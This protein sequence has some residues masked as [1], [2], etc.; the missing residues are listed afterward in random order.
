M[1]NITLR[2]LRYFDALA[3]TA[4]FGRAAEA[5]AISQPAL[6]VQIKELEEHLGCTLFE[7]TP[8]QV[9][10][11]TLG[12]AFL[13][14]SRTILRDVDELTDLARSAREHL[15]GELRIGI[16]PTIA[17]YMLPSIV[18][19]IS[20]QFSNVEIHVRETMTKTLIRELNEG[21]IDIAIVALPIDEP[22]LSESPLFD[23]NFVLVRP[24]AD[25]DNPVPGRDMLRE[26]KLLLLEEGHCFRDQALSFCNMQS[27]LPRETLDGTT[28]STLVQ[29]VGA[30]MGI[31]LIPEMA[32]PV[33][34]PA[35]DVSVARFAD[36]QPKRKIGMIWRESSPLAEQYRKLSEL[37]QTWGGAGD[38]QFSTNGANAKLALTRK[39]KA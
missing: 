23:E 32:I 3:R 14:R 17:P 8:R 9:R 28:L 35:A 11:T 39:A 21:G 25:K 29:M 7:R 6:S 4:H 26:M 10:L 36:P 15:V 19:S 12:R 20:E 34:V 24:E 18:K 16:I 22:G 38:V 33:E 30:G 1:A 27:N 37:L 2:Q 13:E 5:C 31:T